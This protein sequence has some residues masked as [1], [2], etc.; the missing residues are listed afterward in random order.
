MHVVTYK[1][2]FML[3]EQLHHHDIMT[4]C[5][6]QTNK[7]NGLTTWLY[8]K[9]YTQTKLTKQLSL[10]HVLLGHTVYAIR[11]ITEP[12]GLDIQCVSITSE[13]WRGCWGLPLRHQHSVSG[14]GGREGDKERLKCEES[15]AHTLVASFQVMSELGT[16]VPFRVTEP[17]W[18]DRPYTVKRWRVASSSPL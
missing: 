13:G 7:T 14:E 1:L 18:L 8:V 10:G 11:H 5:Y 15:P 12:E 16:A 9:M 6:I 2:H 17:G 3:L 4:K